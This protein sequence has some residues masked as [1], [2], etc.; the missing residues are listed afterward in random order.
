[1]EVRRISSRLTSFYKKT[2]PVIWCGAVM[3]VAVTTWMA[4]HTGKQGT[5][6][7]LIFPLLMV[8]I[9]YAL[10]RNLVADIVDEV[11]LEGEAIIVKNRDELAKIPLSDVTDVSASTMMNPRRITLTLRSDTQWGHRIT[12]MPAVESVSFTYSFKPDPIATELT[13]RIDALRTSAS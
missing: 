5:L 6:A 13:S 7:F 9:G 4:V 10:Y 2:F 11:W 3:I 1:M 8:A 12:F